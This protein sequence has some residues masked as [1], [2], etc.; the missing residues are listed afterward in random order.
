MRMHGDPR[1]A[2][3]PPGKLTACVGLWCLA[4]G[5]ALEWETGGFVPT[6]QVELLGGTQAEARHLVAAGIWKLADGELGAPLR[7][8]VFVAPARSTVEFDG[9][10]DPEAHRRELGAA[11]QQR[12]RARRRE[13]EERYGVTRVT[14]ERNGKG[15]PSGVTAK[16]DEPV[17]SSLGGKGG[18]EFSVSSLSSPSV[19]PSPLG[20]SPQLPGCNAGA[21]D[22]DEPNPSRF[23]FELEELV[24]AE[25][26][27]RHVTPQ[28]A[29]A[30]QWRDGCQ[31]V[32]DALQLGAYPDAR[33]AMRAFAKALVDACAGGKPLGLALQQTPLGEQ[34]KPVA[35]RRQL[36][37]LAQRRLAEGT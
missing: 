7:G 25:F 15:L 27:E 26:F 1:L 20:S 32:A 17:T 24:R 31:T 16:R 34:L 9:E 11:R 4:A 21:R 36:S 3:L 12:Y 13:T 23:K 2:L 5:W 30:S 29:P 22:G 37:E 18:S 6:R 28:K 33:S 10:G 8:Y 14:R 35:P 19:S